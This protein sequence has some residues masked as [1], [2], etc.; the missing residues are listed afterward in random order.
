MAFFGMLFVWVILLGAALGVGTFTAQ[1]AAESG[2]SRVRWGALSVTAAILGQLF[3]LAIFG[4][5]FRPEDVSVSFAGF[6]LGLLTSLAGPLVAMFVVL[7]VL[8]RLPI[9]APSMVGARWPVYRVAADNR[10]GADCVLSIENDRVHIGD[11]LVLDPKDIAEVAVDGECLRVTWLEQVV[12][13]RPLGRKLTRR[14][15]SNRALGLQ[16]RLE[17]LLMRNRG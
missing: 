12:L 10:P 8:T 6:I 15:R 14:E 3:G 17:G 5:S 13:L 7:L 11:E 4:W 16:K 9:R 1:R 2:R